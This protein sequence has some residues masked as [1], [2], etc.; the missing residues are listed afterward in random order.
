M[1][2]YQE[3]RCALSVYMQAEA[4]GNLCRAGELNQM[5]REYQQQAKSLR[6]RAEVLL[7]VKTAVRELTGG[8][9]AELRQLIDR[10]A[11]MLARHASLDTSKP[12]V[13]M[14]LHTALMDMLEHTG[15]LI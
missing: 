11:D 12:S 4:H 1:I 8:P 10:E 14:S 7:K 3:L 15:L 2:L 5:Y 9:G 13:W 6:Q